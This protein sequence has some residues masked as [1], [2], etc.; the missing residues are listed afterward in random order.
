[1]FARFDGALI[2]NTS[3]KSLGKSTQRNGEENARRAAILS[4]E[5]DEMVLAEW[6]KNKSD[7]DVVNAVTPTTSNGNEPQERRSS[8]ANLPT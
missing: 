8:H 6:E 5:S 7:G 4:I 2:R 1:M 3:S